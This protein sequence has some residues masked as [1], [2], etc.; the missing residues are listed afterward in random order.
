MRY[1]TPSNDVIHIHGFDGA[2]P[3]EFIGE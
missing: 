3:A 1:E 2:L